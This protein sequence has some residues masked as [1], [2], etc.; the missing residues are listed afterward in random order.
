MRTMPGLK[1][2]LLRTVVLLP[3]L[4]SGCGGT[5]TKPEYVERIAVSASLYVG[6]TVSN[7]N[8]I[9]LTRTRPVDEYYDADE[10]AIQGAIV[11]LRADDTALDDTLRMAAPGRYANPAVVIRPHTTY[12]LKV[13]V[14]GATITASTTT[15]IA[16]E[17]LR[18]P[19]VVPDVMRQSAIADSFPLVVSCGD[20]EQVFLV[21]VYCLEEYQNASY[22]YR[23]GTA[24]HPKDYAEYGGDSGEPRHIS[25]YFR[26]K[27]LGAG[28]AGYRISFYGDMM[29]F[30]GEYL[31]G[32]FS[33]DQNYYNYLYR[34]HPELSGGINGGIGV[35]GSACRRQYHVKTVE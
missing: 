20:P 9:L 1:A 5:P 33:I 14:G 23:I 4:L 18:V 21:D 12:H 27:D 35:F 2:V 24:E 16:F 10:A 31:V 29:A 34:D 13:Q 8:A 17:V 6:E 22:V 15:P 32:V 26:L 25:T 11:T 28:E 19:R 7:A 30:Y 3:L